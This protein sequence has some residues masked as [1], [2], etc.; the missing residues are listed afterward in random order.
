M[1]AWLAEVNPEKL[2]VDYSSIE[3]K[4]QTKTGESIAYLKEALDGTG[5]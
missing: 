5:N 2:R 3:E 1:D 4:I